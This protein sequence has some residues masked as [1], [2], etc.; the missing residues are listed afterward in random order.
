MANEVEL[1]SLDLRYEGFRLKQPAAEQRLL[2]AITQRGVEEPLEGVE[3][4][5]RHVL[6][7]GFKGY[8]CARRLRLATVPYTR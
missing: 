1:G 6:L 8:R 7:N 4:Q 2:V 5:A 3:V